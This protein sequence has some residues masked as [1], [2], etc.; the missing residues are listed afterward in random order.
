MGKK[1][2]T[3][4][5]KKVADVRMVVRHSSDKEK[6]DKFKKIGVRV[7]QADFL[8]VEEI[9]KT[10]I[11]V[12]CVVSALQ[13]LQEVIVD[14]QSMFLDAAIAASVPRFIPSGFSLDYTKIGSENRNFDLRR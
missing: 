8:N 9:S 5:C 10:C 1:S 7:T 11:D 12:S 14:A 3:L 2:L 6:V 13:G 4:Y